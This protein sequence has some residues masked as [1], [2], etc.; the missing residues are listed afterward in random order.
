MLK[1]EER[2]KRS[3]KECCIQKTQSRK[4]H[5]HSFHLSL[6][7]F[8]AQTKQQVLKMKDMPFPF[9]EFQGKGTLDYSS[10]DT[11]DSVSFSS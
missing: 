6:Q 10:A 9:E 3:N 5:I 1:R 2:D 11:S 8:G 4:N 7:L